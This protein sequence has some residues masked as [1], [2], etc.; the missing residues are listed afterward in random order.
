MLAKRAKPIFVDAIREM[1]FND[2]MNILMGNNDAATR[3]LENKTYQKLVAEFSPVIIESLDKFQ[4]R[5]FWKKGA[6]A[7]NN[8]PLTRDKVNASLDQYVTEQALKGLF[9]MVEKE[10]TRIR[11][12]CISSNYRLVKKGVCQ[13]G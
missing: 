5:E 1:T 11:T 8:F 4:A 10:E 6:D 7:Y 3:Y 2:A 9:S 13:T 12:K